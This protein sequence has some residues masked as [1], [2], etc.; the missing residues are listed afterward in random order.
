MVT[1]RG[2]LL[3]YSKIRGW[4]LCSS[5]VPHFRARGQRR[6]MCFLVAYDGE[7]IWSTGSSSL[8]GHRAIAITLYDGTRR[9]YSWLGN[10]GPLLEGSVK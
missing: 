7:E 4:V 3:Q 6:E 2:S 10:Q 9:W 8:L 1:Q 5:T